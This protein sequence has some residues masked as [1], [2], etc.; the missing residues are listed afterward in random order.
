MVRED[1]NLLTA[2]TAPLLQWVH[3]RRTVVREGA[4]RRS[5]PRQAGFNGSTVGEPW[6]GVRYVPGTV[7]TPSF[8][9]STVGEPW[10]GWSELEHASKLLALQ[11]VHG[12]RTVVRERI[13]NLVNSSA[14][15]QWVHGRRTVV[16]ST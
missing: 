12:R 15:L 14:P 11:W 4:P 13:D 3:G 2:G 9:G 8:N 1:G 5:T 10:L 6:L 16:R 7:L